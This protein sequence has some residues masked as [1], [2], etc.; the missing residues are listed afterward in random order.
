MRDFSTWC[1]VIAL[2]AGC[3]RASEPAVTGDIAGEASE[4]DREEVAADRIRDS[5]QLDDAHRCEAEAAALS[6]SPPANP[7]LRAWA[8]HCLASVGRQA[9]AAAMAT[10]MQRE[11]PGE[12]WAEFLAIVVA[13]EAGDVGSSALDG[14]SAAL[15]TAL[16][17]PDAVRLRLRYLLARD[18]TDDALALLDARPELA[19]VAGMRAWALLQ[20]SYSDRTKRPAAL[21]AAAAM[22]DGPAALD[23]AYAAAY[24]LWRYDQP[25][26]ALP[27]VE[28]A[29]AIS[30]TSVAV[31]R[32]RL[33]ILRG[34]QRESPD[35]E[36]VEPAIARL[37]ELRPN[38]P[39]ALAAA[40][41]TYRALGRTAPADALEARLVG[42]FA[43]SAAT[44]ELLFEQLLAAAGDAK[45]TPEL[46]AAQRDRAA[47]FLARPRLH[48]QDRRE[49]AAV[50]QFDVLRA[51]PTTSPE[52]LLAGVE[53]MVAN[54]RG[55]LHAAYVFG[56]LALVERTPYLERAEAIAR[57]GLVAMDTFL[58]ERGGSTPP[59]VLKTVR[60][61]LEATIRDALGAVL[62]AA[63]RLDDAEVELRR[64]QKLAPEYVPVFVHLA[65]LVDK[66]G[67]LA[68]AQELLVECLAYNSSEPRHLC[69]VELERMHLAAHGDLRGFRG[70][71][72]RLTAEVRE[73]RR[74]DVLATRIAEPTAPPA[75]EL[76]RL[77]GVKVASAGLRGKIVV[78][79]FWF[80]TCKPCVEEL[81]E[82]QK[83]ADDYANDPE[84]EV[85]SIY[86]QGE[87]D[88]VNAWMRERG[89]NFDV[90]LAGDYC[91]ES[92]VNS[93]PTLWVLD[94][95]GKLAY[96]RSGGV[97]RLREEFGWRVESL[98][99]SA[100]L[101]R[102]T[103]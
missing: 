15:L 32:V 61:D 5:V 92:K 70:E 1:L 84:V 26:E 11:L 33:D 103:G 89:Y 58:A 8:G 24:W 36:L 82:F 71:F 76:E 96:S 88:E 48:R 51:E 31:H 38:T 66:R 55:E 6:Q 40:I 74:A 37:L 21:A 10:A 22:R 19:E 94:R 100:R 9:E 3:G 14:R 27:E 49:G 98:R 25:A 35:R 18:R 91:E 53:A 95:D 79:K 20:G 101:N 73:K 29:L 52:A 50:L 16:D 86:N 28:R 45:R 34:L 47:A 56:V 75:F 2:M 81:P 102:V 4:R 13:V 43:D 54:V 93:F 46:R 90:L 72:E 83:L 80:N 87:R 62:V 57:Q 85:V 42:E 39:A 17:H 67:D 78:I 23:A 99:R 7:R 63:G 77:D 68:R 65:A 97:Q 64:A 60:D 30:P 44:E 41:S 69:E 12:P 59:A